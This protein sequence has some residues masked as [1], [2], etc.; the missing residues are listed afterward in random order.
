MNR[1]FFSYYEA[2]AGGGG[3]GGNANENRKSGSAVAA[4]S[5]D[6]F[7]FARTSKNA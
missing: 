6:Y 2:I 3:G 1:A 7:S 4:R 5:S